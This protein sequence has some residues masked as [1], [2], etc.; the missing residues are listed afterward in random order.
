MFD[1]PALYVLFCELCFSLLLSERPRSYGTS[2]ATTPPIESLARMDSLERV[3]SAAQES[4]H[5][6]IGNPP[7]IEQRLES[8]NNHP[9]IPS[10]S[11]LV[12]SRSQRA[13][14]NY[15]PSSSAAPY[16]PKR[17]SSSWGCGYDHRY[18]THGAQPEHFQITKTRKDELKGNTKPKKETFDFGESKEISSEIPEYEIKYLKAFPKTSPESLS[19]FRILGK[20]LNAGKKEWDFSMGIDMNNLYQAKQKHLINVLK[21]KT[22]ELQE[23]CIFLMNEI[24]YP[25]GE[26]RYEAIRAQIRQAEVLEE[27]EKRINSPLGRPIRENLIMVDSVL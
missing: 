26:R 5:L 4:G 16:S 8:E 19:R 21:C 14:S 17:G 3:A 25:E 2:A 11:L 20:I 1:I 24:G 7:L 23:Q 13:A 27:W 18:T 15:N 22:P 12:S 6:T 10:E 9:L